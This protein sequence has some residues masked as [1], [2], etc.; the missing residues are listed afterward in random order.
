MKLKNILSVLF[1]LSFLS[2]CKKESP[3][4][5]VSIRTPDWVY[6]AITQPVPSWGS[7]TRLQFPAGIGEIVFSAGAGIGA[8]GSHQGGHPEGLNHVWIY[9][10]TSSP[11]KSWADGKVTKIEDTGGEYFLTIQYNDGL[12]GKHM[13]VKTPIVSVGQL[14]KAG[15]PVCY[16]SMYG[17]MQS[18]EFMLNDKNRNDGEVAGSEGSYVSPFDYLR[19]D[20]RHSLEAAYTANV[21]QPYLSAGKAVGSQRPVEPYLTNQI[22]FHKYHKNSIAGEWLLKSK[23]GA[24]GS[25]DIVTLIDADNE[26]YKGKIVEAADNVGSGQHLFDG[27]WTVDA[28]VNHFSFITDKG[29]YYGLYELNESGERA[30]LKIEYQTGSYPAAFTSNAAQYIER[31]NM[32]IA[33]DAQNMG[34]W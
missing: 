23:W 29:T 28:A 11:V 30:L 19:D 2:G 24:G 1:I 27:T 32:P 7:S 26:F 25:P 21:I 16:G 31:A 20:I 9:I 17:G 6:G 13:D 3:V 4:E 8:F 34:V 5:P 14:V 15:D 22:I 12:L 33:T 18:A 10:A